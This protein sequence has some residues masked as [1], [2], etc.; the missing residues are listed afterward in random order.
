MNER[1]DFPETQEERLVELRAYTGW[2]AEIDALAKTAATAGCLIAASDAATARCF[3]AMESSSLS[4]ATIVVT[5]TT[6]RYGWLLQPVGTFF[7]VLR[8]ELLQRLSK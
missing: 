8:S 1:P 5:A 7:A 6:P 2:D 3:A 4:S